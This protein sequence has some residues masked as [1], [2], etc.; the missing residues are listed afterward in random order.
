MRRLVSGKERLPK[1][2]LYVNLFVGYIHV[3]V[4]EIEGS[5]IMVSLFALHFGIHVVKLYH[6]TVCFS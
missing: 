5:G 4:E 3:G 2:L 1:D 6:G